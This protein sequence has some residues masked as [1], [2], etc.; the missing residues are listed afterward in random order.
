MPN[1]INGA[2]MIIPPHVFLS[3]FHKNPARYFG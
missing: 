2:R 3:S 1:R